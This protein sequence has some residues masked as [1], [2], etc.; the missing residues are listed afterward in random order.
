MF[1]WQM[2]R[3]AF[4]EVVIS[5]EPGAVGAL[6][7]ERKMFVSNSFRKSPPR[8]IRIHLAIVIGAVRGKSIA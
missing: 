7:G 2:Q 4:E 5:P 8:F 1:T 6:R 3:Q